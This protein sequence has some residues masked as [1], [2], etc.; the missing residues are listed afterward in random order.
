ME[1]KAGGRPWKEAA[2][3]MALLGPFFFLTYGLCNWISSQQSAAT[4]F[5]WDWEKSIPFVPIFILPYMSIDA[6]FAAS[7]FLCGTRRELHTVVARILFAISASG[8][9]FLLH[10]MRY[11]FH[12]PPVE[13]WL[14]PVFAPLNANDLPYNLAPSLHISLRAIL[15]AVYGRHLRGW[16]RGTVKTWFILI[17]LST[18][19]VWQHHFVDV[20][21]GFS[22]ALFTIYVFPDHA[23]RTLPQALTGPIPRKIGSFYAALAAISLT[24]APFVPYGLWL[25]WPA[26]AFGMA[27]AA[28]F[29]GG[30]AVFQ[31][32][33]GAI[34]AAAEWALLPWILLSRAVQWHWRRQ[35]PPWAEL[36]GNVLLGRRLSG[37]EAR[38]G[39]RQGVVAT[40]DL[41]GESTEARV[42]VE[43]TVYRQLSVL[44]I[45]APSPEVLDA[46]VAFL[47]EQTPRG[48]VYVHCELGFS[49]SA[50]VAAAWLLAEGFANTAENAIAQVCA[51]RPQA[52]FREPERE[53]VTAFARR[54]KV[55]EGAPMQM[56]KQANK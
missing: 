20:V 5:Y 17:G 41:A 23:A 7:L 36:P 37:E 15:W 56:V 31:K 46:A 33:H 39:L 6:F 4:G 51:A 18:L 38:A 12:R 19:L 32:H 21:T 28:Y 14:G 42:F 34:S 11:G 27:A 29:G 8:I 50:A 55:A 24:L 13:G 30:P 16:L 10:P 52:R 54:C 9:C 40:L 2:L 53:A 45:T 47:R 48:R 25:L 35:G 43:K 3:W 26:L 44:D 49:R 22:M 1:S